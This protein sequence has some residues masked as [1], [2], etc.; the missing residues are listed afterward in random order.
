MYTNKKNIAVFWGMLLLSAIEII[1]IFAIDKLPYEEWIVKISDFIIAL[2]ISQILLKKLIAGRIITFSLFYIS[3]VYVFHLAY[4]ILLRISY[5]FGSMAYANPLIRYDISSFKGAVFYS[6]N[7]IIIL[8][9]ITAILEVGDNRPEGFKKGRETFK[10]IDY[11]NLAFLLLCTTGVLDLFYF[12]IR[13]YAMFLSGYSGTRTIYSNSLIELLTYFPT[14]AILLLFCY[15]KDKIKRCRIIMMI[16]CLYRV[17]YMF[18]GLRGYAL[19]QI[20]LVLFFYYSIVEKVN[21]RKLIKG[22]VAAA[23][24]MWIL[25]IIR[26]NRSNGLSLEMF[27]IKQVGNIFF[28]TLSEFGITINVVCVVLEEKLLNPIGHQTIYTLL[29]VIPRCKSLFP[30]LSNEVLYSAMETNKYGGSFIADSIFD[31]G[32]YWF[33]FIIFWGIILGFVSRKITYFIQTKQYHKV[34]VCIPFLTYYVFCIRSSSIT[35][36][37]YVL[38]TIIIMNILIRIS[39]RLKIGW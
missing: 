14:A 8:Y 23:L 30:N 17:I 10:L 9:F 19:V 39:R 4:V 24:L 32:Q 29:A 5:D 35:L 36:V 7:S 12:F 13:I 33:V 15:H 11:K 25:L 16:Y 38:W 37:R 6:V 34:A 3:L 2:L 22:I 1:I 28:D 27:S 20:L 18:C 21:L 31:F 26:E